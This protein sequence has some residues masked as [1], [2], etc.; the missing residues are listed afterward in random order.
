MSNVYCIKCGELNGSIR[1]TCY[2]CGEKLYRIGSITQV[3][4]EYYNFNSNIEYNYPKSNNTGIVSRKV[5]FKYLCSNE[6]KKRCKIISILFYISIVVI[7]FFILSMSS[8]LFELNNWGWASSNLFNR[9]TGEVIPAEQI[10]GMKSFC[11]ILILMYIILLIFVICLYTS[12]NIVFRILTIVFSVF[13]YLLLLPVA[14]SMVVLIRNVE[15]EYKLY[16][17]IKLNSFIS[18]FQMII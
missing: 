1:A 18:K 14:I 17:K 3:G 13:T 10:V 4:N 15:K 2:K 5:Y 8:V 9:S 6:A 16:E 11:F 7:G 12:H